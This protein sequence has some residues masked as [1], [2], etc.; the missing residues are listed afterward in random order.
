MRRR[1]VPKSQ[2][3]F[4]P[5]A[6]LGRPGWVGKQKKGGRCSHR[7]PHIWPGL[8]PCTCLTNDDPRPTNEGTRPDD[9]PGAVNSPVAVT[10]SIAIT[11]IPI[12]AAIGVA[13]AD[14]NA[15][16]TDANDEG[17]GRRDRSNS[18]DKGE[19][20][21]YDERFHNGVLS[22]GGCHSAQSL[23][24]GVVPSGV[25]AW[26]TVAP[27]IRPVPSSFASAKRRGHLRLL[28]MVC[29]LDDRG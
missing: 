10:S 12:P 15:T 26:S 11:A 1:C 2:L 14:S 20:G 7:R 29:G 18:H 13:H 5:A 9:D 6:G 8:Y 24:A 3:E 4:Q 23:R 27:A 25:V 21:T 28:K 19:N 17:R 16:G 22:G